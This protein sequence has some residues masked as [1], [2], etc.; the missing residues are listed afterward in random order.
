MNPKVTFD[1]TQGEPILAVFNEATY[2]KEGFFQKGRLL[3]P[4]FIRCRVL[5]LIEYA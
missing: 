3:A 5:F 4:A 1:L 2:R